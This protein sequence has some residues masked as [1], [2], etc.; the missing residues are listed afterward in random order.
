MAIRGIV[1]DKDGT[2]FQYQGT[3]ARWCDAVLERLCCGDAALKATLADAVGFDLAR[4]DFLAGSLIVGGSAGEVNE[5]WAAH[6]PDTTVAEID[7][8]AVEELSNLPNLPVCDLKALFSELSARGIKLGIATNDY[9]AGA[10]MQL[11][12]AQI[13]E[14]FSFVCGFDSGYGAKPGAGM[15]EGFCKETGLPVNE[16]AMVG[17]STHDLGAGRAAKVALNVGVLTGPAGRDDIIHLA[18]V[19][20]ED[21]S[22]LPRLLDGLK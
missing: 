6:L 5:A 19:V 1:F 14:F 12:D 16:V 15:I 8:I 22:E 7:A 9:E 4:Q 21:I 13:G 2:L 18:D 17:D 10:T 20:L 11:K 3:W